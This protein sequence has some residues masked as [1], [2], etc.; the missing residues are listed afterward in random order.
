[1]NKLK[2][3]PGFLYGEKLIAL[4]DFC[5]SNNCA[6]P[7][8]N[9]SS[10]NTVNAALSAAAQAK[11]PII[12]QL[13]HS[14]SAFFAGKS[15]IND[16]HQASILGAAS[17]AMYVKALAIA[18]GV[19]VI[20]HSDHCPKKKLA[21]VDGMLEIGGEYY[22]DYG[23]PLFSSHMLD[24]SEENVDENIKISTKYLKKMAALEMLLEVEI[25]ITGG[26]E[27]GL[28]NEGVGLEKLYSKPEDVYK[29][30]LTLSAFGN[31]NIA[32]TFG[33][34][35][36]VYADKSVKLKPEILKKCQEFAFDQ[37]SKQAEFSKQSK[38]MNLVFH[39]GSG[40]DPT[41][42]KESLKYGVVKFNI[43]TDTQWAFAA[44]IKKYMDKNDQY[45]HSQVGNNKD[46]SAPN[47]K[48]ID[49]R[50]WL[51]EAEDG[52]SNKLVQMFELLNCTNKFEILD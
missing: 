36:G 22:S 4:F 27:D 15:L 44:P 7:A 8:V 6:I 30:F 25:G 47:K 41:K 42:I 9:V 21:W 26:E 13:S 19:P 38:P 28:N 5:K 48:Y 23:E 49:P 11:S 14:G 45:L 2:I 20:I 43:D 32:A 24:L 1:M 39:G 12:I 33:N 18:Y 46:K 34:V 31:V 50:V 29:A 37:M 51:A 40:S 10:S 3:E 17:V 16:E 52:M 35:H